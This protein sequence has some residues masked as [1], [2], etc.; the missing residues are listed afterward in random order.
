MKQSLQLRLGQQLAMTPQLQQAIRLLQ[1]STLELHVEIQQLL[2]SNMMLEMAEDDLGSVEDAAE[3]VAPLD[4]PAE[5]ATDTEWDDIFESTPS[6]LP[7]SDSGVGELELQQSSDE[8]LADH[9]QWQLDLSRFSDRDQVIAE[10]IIDAIDD[11]GYLATSLEDL[12][13]S[14]AEGLDDLDYYELT[15]V[16][17]QVQNFDPPGVGARD[18]RDCLLVQLRQL[19]QDVKWREQAIE[20]VET[21]LDELASKDFA[22]LVKTMRLSREELHEV[23]QLVQRM[24]P[25]PGATSH[26]APAEYVTPD[27]IVAKHKGVWTVELNPEAIPRVRVNSTYAGFIRRADSSPDNSSMRSHLQEARWFIKSLQSR[28]ETLLKVARCI[29][30]RQEAF[31]EHGDEAMKAMVLHDVADI[32]GM[33]ESTISRVTTQK[34]MLT[35][36]GL[37]E[38]KFFFSSH[39]ATD[40]GG[41]ASS[42]AIR[43]LLKK[44]IATESSTKP[45]SD[46]KLASMLKGQGINVARRTVA[47]YRESMAIPS[48]SDRKQLA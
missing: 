45:L 23:T 8:T 4:I 27:V 41:E 26:P 33:H 32:V 34:Y 39:V 29:V 10:A 11:D 38:L 30:D 40:T 47:K 18:L 15:A 43:A 28:S 36:R 9:L 22:A 17:R 20:L 5:L 19:D 12:H 14:L 21:C 44:L 6:S 16:L 31:L 7:T 46:N 42:I 3:E 35:P 2:D 37:Y 25:R 13:L 24:N 1:L 48:S